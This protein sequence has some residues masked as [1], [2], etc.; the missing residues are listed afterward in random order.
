MK[1]YKYYAS[2]HGN[3]LLSEL[4]FFPVYILMCKECETA[5]R[6]NSIAELLAQQEGVKIDEFA[7]VSLNY[8]TTRIMRPQQGVVSNFRKG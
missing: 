5:K 3:L 8:Q 1:N 6:F 4:C 2:C 7:V